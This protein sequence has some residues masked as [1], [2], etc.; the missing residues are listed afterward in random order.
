MW[1]GSRRSRGAESNNVCAAQVDG[2]P[3]Y[4]CCFELQFE[5]TVFTACHDKRVRLRGRVYDPTTRSWAELS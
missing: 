4:Q 3:S 2:Q 1:L 5:V